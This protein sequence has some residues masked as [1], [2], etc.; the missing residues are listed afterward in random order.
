MSWIDIPKSSTGF[1]SFAGTPDLGNAAYPYY[2]QFPRGVKSTGDMSCEG[3]NLGYELFRYAPTGDVATPYIWQGPLTGPLGREP[4]GIYVTPALVDRVYGLTFNGNFA[5]GILASGSDSNA[6]TQTMFL[7]QTSCYD[8]GP[9]LGFY[10]RIATP[11]DAT[12]L[13]T[14][15]VYY[16]VASNCTGSATAPLNSVTGPLS[17]QTSCLVRGTTDQYDSQ[18]TGQVAIPI[19]TGRNSQGRLNFRYMAYLVSATV[20]R[21]DVRDPATNA[22]LW[23][24]DHTLAAFFLNDAAKMWNKQFSTFVTFGI[25]K[26]VLRDLDY[27]AKADMTAD[28][29]DYPY[30]GAKTIGLAQ[31]PL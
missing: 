19:P 29:Q 13:T 3:S 23:T 31:W 9:E 10:R 25:Q 18:Q 22:V 14:M 27:H 21:I 28:P 11:G 20:L 7:H 8:G 2:V 30:A 5:G 24:T 1:R 16:C 6:L 4:G 26:Q 15:Y 12:E 17:T